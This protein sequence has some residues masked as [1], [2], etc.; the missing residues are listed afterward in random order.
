MPPEFMQPSRW[1]YFITII[2]A[3]ITPGSAWRPLRANARRY[4]SM[5]PGVAGAGRNRRTISRD[6]RGR[7]RSSRRARLARAP[8]APPLSSDPERF[9]AQ[10]SV[11]A[12]DL[13]EL[14]Q[15]IAPRARRTSELEV[16]VSE[17]RCGRIVVATTQAINGRRVTVQ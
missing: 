8:D 2:G 1:G 5:Y 16:A 4:L 10:R 17:R 14:A 7:R 15:R 12:H 13:A 6:P 9:H 11:I 3:G